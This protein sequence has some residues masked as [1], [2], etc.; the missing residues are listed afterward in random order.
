MKTKTATTTANT[1]KTTFHRNGTVTLWNVYTQGWERRRAA[2][3]ADEVLASLSGS[4]RA[5]ILRMAAK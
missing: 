2:N 4:E 1:Y 5:R 3:V